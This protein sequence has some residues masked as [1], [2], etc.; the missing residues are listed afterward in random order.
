MI[1]RALSLSLVVLLSG[2]ASAQEAPSVPDSVWIAAEE[3][4]NVILAWTTQI[5]DDGQEIEF[6]RP[7]RSASGRKDCPQG[8]DGSPGEISRRGEA[9]HPPQ[10]SPL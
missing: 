8:S 3:S 10:E 2:T 1:P 6:A 9:E 5:P 7:T 4:G